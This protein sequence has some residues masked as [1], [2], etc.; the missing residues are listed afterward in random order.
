MNK[1]LINMINIQ[2][3]R[4]INKTNL[5]AS[6]RVINKLLHYS[7]RLN[8]YQFYIDK[9]YHF[10]FYTDGLFQRVTNLSGVKADSAWL[11]VHP[12]RLPLQYTFRYFH[13]T[14]VLKSKL[15]AILVA[16]LVC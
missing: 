14:S 9:L 5:L 10:K 11:L 1:G 3:T 6:D 16:I 12:Y 7:K 8:D 4:F 2:N 13:F 15:L